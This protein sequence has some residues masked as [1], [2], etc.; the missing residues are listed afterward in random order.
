MKKLLFIPVSVSVGVLA[1]MLG[2]PVVNQV[3]GWIDDQDPPEPSHRFAPW[4]KV[5]TAAAIQ[6]AIFRVIR[7]LVDRSLRRGF[8]SVTGSWPGDTSPDAK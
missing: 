4:W 8:M 1:G 2:K 5:L 6:G 3:W 7:A